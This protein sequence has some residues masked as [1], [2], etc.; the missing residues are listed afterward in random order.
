MEA[1]FAAMRDAFAISAVP[2]IHCHMARYFRTSRGRSE[3]VAAPE[4]EAEAGRAIPCH[5]HVESTSIA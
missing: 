4:I 2:V 5:V 1:F 3:Y